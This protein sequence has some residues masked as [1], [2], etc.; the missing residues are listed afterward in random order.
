M[1]YWIQICLM[2]YFNL[3]HCSRFLRRRIYTRPYHLLLHYRYLHGGN[4]SPSVRWT[5]RHIAHRHV[6]I[7]PYYHRR[8]LRGHYRP[9][10]PRHCHHA[11]AGHLQRSTLN[12]GLVPTRGEEQHRNLMRGLLVR[13]QHRNVQLIRSRRWDARLHHVVMDSIQM[14]LIETYA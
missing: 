1:S 14:I 13:P 12:V 8:L 9:A 7:R 5:S 2:L 3:T 11:T 6:R 4:K 10:C